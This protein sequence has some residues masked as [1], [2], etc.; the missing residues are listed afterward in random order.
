MFIDTIGK[1]E[2][3]GEG[4][5]GGNRVYGMQGSH[6]NFR[7]QFTGMQ[8]CLLVLRQENME[9]KS[10]ITGLKIS[11]ERNVRV[12]NGNVRRLAMRPTRNLTVLATAATNQ[13][14]QG[15]VAAQDAGGDHAMMLATLMPT[16][17]SFS[18]L[19]QEFEF[20]VGGRK[21]AKLFSY[22]ER[23]HFKDKYHRRKNV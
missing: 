14:S 8:S 2:Q 11:I 6:A 17:R 3:G 19:W 18:D 20:G 1:L 21:A 23:G 12:V 16:P 5:G 9:M 4:G 13:Q 15:G 7:N 10:T 22:T